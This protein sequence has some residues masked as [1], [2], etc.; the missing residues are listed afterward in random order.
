M[1]TLAHLLRVNTRVNSNMTLLLIVAPMPPS[2]TFTAP[3]RLVEFVRFTMPNTPRLGSP[4][5]RREKKRKNTTPPL[6][7]TQ[8][9]PGNH[10]PPPPPPPHPSPPKPRLVSHCTDSLVKVARF[11][12]AHA[13]TDV[14]LIFFKKTK[15]RWRGNAF[16]IYFY[17]CDGHPGW[18]QQIPLHRHRCCLPPPMFP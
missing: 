16:Q 9:H 18:L 3:P 15:K 5:S 1:R 17:P 7:T 2:F 12:I 4:K 14:F 6:P 13:P 8:N 11:A 10:P